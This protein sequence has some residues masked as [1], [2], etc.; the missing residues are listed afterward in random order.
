VHVIWYTLRLY[1]YISVTI[2]L[3]YEYY[4]YY[5][6]FTFPLWITAHAFIP[7]F[8][9]TI[10]YRSI[11][12]LKQITKD[13]LTEIK[14]KIC[15]PFNLISIFNN[16]NVHEKP[17]LKCFIRRSPV[18]HRRKLSVCL[19]FIYKFFWNLICLSVWF[20]LSCGIILQPFLLR[21]MQFKWFLSL[22]G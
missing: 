18:W 8:F 1:L 15:V 21:I 7:G 20:Y 2:F 10:L 19:L 11:L 22:K 4:K 3:N 9:R 13:K 17:M 16:F 14:S 5:K 12:I 6:C